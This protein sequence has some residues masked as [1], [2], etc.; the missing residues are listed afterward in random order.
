MLGT[1]EN[2]VLPIC[3]Y[4]G[5]LDRPRDL[6]KIAAVVADDARML[7]VFVPGMFQGDDQATRPLLEP[8]Q[9][10]VR[11]VVEQGA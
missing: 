5:R 9:V 4:E 1:L 6:I 10:V 11:P 3:A 7:L 8:G 2:Q